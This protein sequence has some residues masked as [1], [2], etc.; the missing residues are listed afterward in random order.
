MAVIRRV[1]FLAATRNAA[2]ILGRFARI[3]V[4]FLISAFRFVKLKE[5]QLN[6]ISLEIGFAS[7]LAPNVTVYRMSLLWWR[8]LLLRNE[9][10]VVSGKLNRTFV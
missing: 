10:V 5:A 2:L 3:R 6:A 8:L 7:A 9:L 4:A 1:P